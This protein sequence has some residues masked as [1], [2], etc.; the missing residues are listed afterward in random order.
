MPFQQIHVDNTQDGVQNL[1]FD[2]DL[3]VG[4]NQTYKVMLWGYEDKE[5]SPLT[6]EAYAYPHTESVVKEAIIKL[7]QMSYNER[8]KYTGVESGAALDGKA[9]GASGGSNHTMASDF[10][11]TLW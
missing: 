8:I 4:D 3:T 6:M 2:T 1:R 11:F 5:G 9:A 10:A 7:N